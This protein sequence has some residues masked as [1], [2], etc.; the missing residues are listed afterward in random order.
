MPRH[1]GATRAGLS[2]PQQLDPPTPVPLCVLPFLSQAPDLRPV[3]TADQ[4]SMAGGCFPDTPTGRIPCRAEGPARE[5]FT[6]GEH[7][8]FSGFLKVAKMLALSEQVKK[9]KSMPPPT[10]DTVSQATEP[11]LV[12]KQHIKNSPCFPILRP[13]GAAGR[14]LGRAGV[15][16]PIVRLLWLAWVWGLFVGAVIPGQR[17]EE[18]EFLARM[19]QITHT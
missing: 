18:A 10:D 7:S 6:L 17:R 14:G 3:V 19:S 4:H 1:N 13:L 16:R 9:K 11:Q 2:L 5:E 15:C 12:D 8:S